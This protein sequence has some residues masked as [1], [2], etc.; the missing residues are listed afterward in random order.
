[1]PGD[2]QRCPWLIPQTIISLCRDVNQRSV[3][4]LHPSGQECDHSPETVQRNVRV[5]KCVIAE[6]VDLGQV[7]R[8]RL[9]E[10][11]LG[12]Y[13]IVWDVYCLANQSFEFKF[14]QCSRTIQILDIFE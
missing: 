10:L 8:S 13:S 5:L 14:F 1:M 4:F 9:R 3:M 6:L 2:W 12:S 11:T 7:F